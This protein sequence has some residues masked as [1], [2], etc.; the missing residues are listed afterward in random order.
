[1]IPG[2]PPP[3]GAELPGCRFAA[4]CE[5]AIDGLHDGP[6]ALRRLEASAPRAACAPRSSRARAAVVA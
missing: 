4:R 1:M 3:V 6:V 5:H 2:Q